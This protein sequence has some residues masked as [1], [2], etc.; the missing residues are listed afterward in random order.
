MESVSPNH[1]FLVKGAECC[2]CL[3]EFGVA[4]EEAVAAGGC[5]QHVATML[6]SLDPPITALRYLLYFVFACPTLPRHTPMQMRAR[7]TQKLR[8]AGAHEQRTDLLHA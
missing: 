4:A 7:D 2:I 1:V 3:D 5:G 6:R 8:A